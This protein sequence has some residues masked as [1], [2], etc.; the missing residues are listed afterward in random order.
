MHAW[1]RIK[2]F[3]K[4]FSQSEI[5]SK[6]IVTE[7]LPFVCVEYQEVNFTELPPHMA[8]QSTSESFPFSNGTYY[9][10]SNDAR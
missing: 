10:A 7:N 1:P 3:W 6:D 8:A 4:I 9:P 2:G 5:L